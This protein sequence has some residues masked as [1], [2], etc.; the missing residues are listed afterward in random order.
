MEAKH[1]PGPWEIMDNKNGQTAI[2]ANDKAICFLPILHPSNEENA[3]L[4]SAAPD[5]LQLCKTL[6]STCSSE[7]GT[8]FDEWAEAKEY[9]R[10]I[11]KLN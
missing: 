6:F 1:T 10:I 9:H 8:M 3:K 11:S 5:L 2:Y 7:Y 4:I